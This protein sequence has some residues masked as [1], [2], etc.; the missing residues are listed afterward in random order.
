MGKIH[1]DG[2]SIV[3]LPHKVVVTVLGGE[4]SDYDSIA[5]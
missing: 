4:G 2:Q 3:C 5:N 1:A